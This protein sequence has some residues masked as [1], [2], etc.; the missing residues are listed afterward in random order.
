[1]DT[2]FATNTSSTRKDGSTLRSRVSKS[3]HHP[4]YLSVKKLPDQVEKRNERERRRVQQVNLGYIKL[5]EHVPK[6]RTNNKKLSKVETLREAAR[7][8]E[9][10]QNLLDSKNEES[11]NDNNILKSTT[12]FNNS[13]SSSSDNDSYYHLGE[14]STY[15]TSTSSI[16]SISPVNVPQ[17][18]D[19]SNNTIHNVNYQQ[20]INQNYY[21]N[22]QGFTYTNMKREESF[23]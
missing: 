13:F 23:Y 19:N 4:S 8:I 10:L 16:S 17:Y 12:N 2:Y 20:M 14:S 3:H 15:T 9:Y 5:G 7:Y 22:Y 1:M 21:N 11:K 6:W 18:Y